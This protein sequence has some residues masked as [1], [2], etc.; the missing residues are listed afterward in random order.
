MNINVRVFISQDFYVR[1][2]MSRIFLM[3]VGS[4]FNSV[5]FK[6]YNESG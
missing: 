1:T 3:D 6:D 4:V 2:F 5:Q